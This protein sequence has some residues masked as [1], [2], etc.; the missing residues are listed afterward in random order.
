MRLN[1]EEYDPDE[2][3]GM[4][5]GP[6]YAESTDDRRENGSFAFGDVVD[7]QSHSSSAAALRANQL[8]QLFVHQA[9]NTEDIQKPYLQRLPDEYAAERVVFD[10]LEFLVLKA[11]FRRSMEALRY[12]QQ[13]GWITER[14][15]S[16]LQEYLLGFTVDVESV[17][18]LE[19][20]DHQLSLVYL[21]RL[22]SMT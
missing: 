5:D 22:A 21:A 3:R 9:A 14:V 18:E 17:H 19:V 20:T 1:P 16:V 12:Y 8:E 7:R 15:L 13:I 6:R 2:L 4:A 11:G 10:W